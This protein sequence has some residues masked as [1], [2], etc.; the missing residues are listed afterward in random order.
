[1]GPLGP[2]NPPSVHRMLFALY[3]RRIDL[4]YIQEDSF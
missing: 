1:M 3:N 2:F 4:K